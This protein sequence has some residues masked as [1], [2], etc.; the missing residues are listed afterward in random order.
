[1]AVE[2]FSNNA[3]TTL[4]AAITT[5]TATSITVASSTA[6]PAIVGPPVGQFRILIDSEIML[7][8]GVSGV[9][10]T[11]TR[12]VEPVAGVTA[13][14]THANGATVTHILTSAA[15]ANAAI[16]GTYPGDL[17]MYGL[18]T[19][20]VGG[21]AP[22]IGTG[23]LLM[24]AGSNVIAV[25]SGG[26]LFTLPVAFPTGILTFLAFPGDY[27]GNPAHLGLSNYLASSSNSQVNLTCFDTTTGAL[28]AGTPNV[29]FNWIA[30][31]F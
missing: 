5:G 2:R 29:R 15:L 13:A 24:Q 9:T 11:V 14:A 30:I 3:Q 12:A 21:S 23:R 7:V 28:I 18:G 17:N 1:M 4:A 22:A 16:D 10:W 19:S 26:I 25:A 27:A 31:G 20:L 8:T 6:F